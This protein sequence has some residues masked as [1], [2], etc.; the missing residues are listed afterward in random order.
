MARHGRAFPIKAHIGKMPFVQNYSFALTVTMMNAASRLTT[1]FGQQMQ[2]FFNL[3]VSMMN[4]ASRLA[5]LTTGNMKILVVNMMNAAS[6]FTTLTPKILVYIFNLSVNMMY[7]VNRLTKF[8][9]SIPGQWNFRPKNITTW[10][11]RPKDNLGPQNIPS[12]P[13]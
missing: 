5:V 7:S 2:F 1:L 11:F 12:Q 8:I 3:S 6:R 4:N 9:V 10:T 13:N